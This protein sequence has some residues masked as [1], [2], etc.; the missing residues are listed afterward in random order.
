MPHFYL[1][2]IHYHQRGSVFI[3]D[4]DVKDG[5]AH[6][7]NSGWR[8]NF[9]VIRLPSDLLN[10]D[11]YATEKNLEQV[12]PVPRIITENHA[13]AWKNFESAAIGNLQ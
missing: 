12:F 8:P 11:L 4:A 1:S 13:R 9:V 7:N 3:L 2:F 5:A 10:L 6:G